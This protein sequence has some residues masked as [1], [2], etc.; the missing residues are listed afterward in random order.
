MDEE[1]CRNF[2]SK[3]VAGHQ[4]LCRLRHACVGWLDQDVTT[5]VVWLCLDMTQQGCDSIK[6]CYGEELVWSAS[7][8]M[9]WAFPRREMWL[10]LLV[11]LIWVLRELVSEV[12]QC[13]QWWDTRNCKLWG[14]FW[15]EVVSLLLWVWQNTLKGRFLARII[16]LSSHTAWDSSLSRLRVSYDREVVVF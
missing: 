6:S 12:W 15:R 2:Y 8:L 9:L 1:E 14:E 3:N 7:L 13:R 11:V 4:G 16:R 5:W 10:K